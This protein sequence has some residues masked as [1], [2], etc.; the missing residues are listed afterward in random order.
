MHLFRCHKL[1]PPQLAAREAGQSGHL[2]GGYMLNWNGTQWK[3]GNKN[4]GRQPS[5]G[6][7]SLAL[8]S[9]ASEGIKPPSAIYPQLTSHLVFPRLFNGLITLLDARRTERDILHFYFTLISIA[10]HF[11]LLNVFQNYLLHLIPYSCL[12]LCLIVSHMDFSWPPNW[13]PCLQHQPI[14]VILHTT[15]RVIFL[16]CKSDHHFPPFL[17]PF[18]DFPW[19]KS[20]LLCRAQK[21][22]CGLVPDSLQPHFWCFTI[23]RPKTDHTHSSSCTERCQTFISLCPCSYFLL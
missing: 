9:W 2:G 8:S 5:F 16:K 14:K 3:N 11:Y 15:R 20:K 1:I 22:L 21:V 19:Q 18:S 13:S 12:G 7:T 23:S 4:L 17:Q 6:H 10:R